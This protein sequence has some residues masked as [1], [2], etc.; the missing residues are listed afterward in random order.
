MLLTPPATD[1][2]C[3]DAAFMPYSVTMI[4]AKIIAAVIDADVVLTLTTLSVHAR[5][6]AA[7]TPRVCYACLRRC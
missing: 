7:F 3:F 1:F 5:L 2:T 6:Y 4:Y